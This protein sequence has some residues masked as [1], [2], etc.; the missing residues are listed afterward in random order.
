MK[1][2]IVTQ[3]VDENHQNL[4]FFVRWIRAFAAECE[5]V[6]V[7]AN[8]VGR[9]ELPKNVTVLSM[10]KERGVS[11]LWRYVTFLTTILGF[12][13]EY[14]T[15]FCHMNP[16]YVLAG[17]WWWRLT[18]KRVGL[19][20]VHG[21]V[22]LRLR[23]ALSLVDVVCTANAESFGIKSPKVR[24]VGHGIDTDYFTSGYRLPHKEKLVIVAGRMAPSKQPKLIAEALVSARERVPVRATFIGGPMIAEDKVYQTE[25]EAQVK[26]VE[27]IKYVGPQPHTF[28]RD[29]VS[30]G[31][32]F[33]NVSRTQSLDKAVLEAMASGTIPLTTNRAFRAMLEPLGLWLETETTTALSDAI[34]QVAERPDLN[35]SAR[36]C[37]TSWSVSIRSRH[38]FRVLFR[39]LLRNQRPACFYYQV[40]VIPVVHPLNPER[41][42]CTTAE[43]EGP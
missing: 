30:A 15:V 8:E 17:G 40:P 35:R 13:N 21:S 3:A 37:V 41:H 24:V 12:S 20:Y 14:D 33:I 31:D 25:F 36:R 6:T 11:R 5:H 22:S 42:V 34:V 39:R 9:Y 23:A 26:D 19:W 4:G 10:G 43:E 28:V 7:L 38:S 32:M 27:Y 18:G 16:E 29:A 1:L 2:L